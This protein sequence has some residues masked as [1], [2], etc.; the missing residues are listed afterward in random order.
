MPVGL[1]ERPGD[2]YRIPTCLNT[3]FL[4]VK[5]AP[6]QPSELWLPTAAGSKEGV[7]QGRSMLG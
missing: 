2:G 6:A 7:N 3:A 1:W 5:P 4:T